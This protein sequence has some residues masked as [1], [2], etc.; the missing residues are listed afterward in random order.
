MQPIKPAAWRGQRR[1]VRRPFPASLGSHGWEVGLPAELILKRAS[2]GFKNVYSI[3]SASAHCHES[4]RGAPKTRRE[5]NS[6]APSRGKPGCLAPPPLPPMCSCRLH[7]KNFLES[8]KSG[9]PGFPALP[10]VTLSS[11]ERLRALPPVPLCPRPAPASALPARAGAAVVCFFPPIAFECMEE[12]EKCVSLNV[13]SP[14]VQ[15]L[16]GSPLRAGAVRESPL[17]PPLNLPGN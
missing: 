10:S 12:K 6:R 5:L 7:G 14:D 16:R 9:A 3:H 8:H 13:F 17:Q 1:A 11:P 15:C 2:A 4:L